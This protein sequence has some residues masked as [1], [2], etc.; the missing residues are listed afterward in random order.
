MLALVGVVVQAT[1]CLKYGFLGDYVIDS[2]KCRNIKQQHGLA[3]C[4]YVSALP[5][6]KVSDTTEKKMVNTSNR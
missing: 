3:T 1:Y 2:M 4:F 6:L 5:K